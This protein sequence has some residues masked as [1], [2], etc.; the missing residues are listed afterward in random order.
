MM[1]CDL[2]KLSDRNNRSATTDVQVCG[3]AANKSPCLPKRAGKVCGGSRL[4]RAFGFL[5]GMINVC[6]SGN[7]ST[8]SFQDCANRIQYEVSK[9]TRSPAAEAK[10]FPLRLYRKKPCHETLYHWF[11]A[12]S[13][14]WKGS[15]YDFISGARGWDVF[16][17]RLYLGW[18]CPSFPLT[19]YCN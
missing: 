18:G 2:R 9:D 7:W 4:V 19:C 11:V 6:Q 10:G 1:G 17:L 12:K 13:T 16:V 5:L 3:A 8:I 14:S 15:D